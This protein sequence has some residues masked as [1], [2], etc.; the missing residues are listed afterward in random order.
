M[1]K[2]K[3]DY[4]PQDKEKGIMLNIFRIETE[5]GIQ[6]KNLLAM[7]PTLC[8]TYHSPEFFVKL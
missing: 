8:E 1:I 5:G 7:N 4:V 3:L 6:D 2:C